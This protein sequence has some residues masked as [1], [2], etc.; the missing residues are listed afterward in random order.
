MCIAV[1]L[2]LISL[3][4]HITIPLKSPVPL[5]QVRR[6]ASKAQHGQLCAIESDDSSKP[7]ALIHHNTQLG[8]RNPKPQERRK[9]N[10]KPLPIGAVEF[11]YRGEEECERH[12]LDE[13]YL[14]PR[15]HVEWVLGRFGVGLAAVAEEAIPFDV[16]L[17]KGGR[18][19]GK[20]TYAL[21]L[22]R[23]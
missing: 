11:G 1:P 13:V 10:V 19:R 14:G 21:L 9:R 16:S 17:E 22:K 20:C 12:V 18:G 3:P 2:I 23:W 7:Y 5:N 8:V 4:P 15:G 6:P